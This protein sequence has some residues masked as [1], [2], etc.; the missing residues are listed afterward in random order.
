MMTK[1][2]LRRMAYQA[3]RHPEMALILHDALLETYPRV[4]GDTIERAE[5]LARSWIV[6]RSAG[7]PGVYYVVFF[8]HRLSGKPRP[9]QL[10]DVYSGWSGDRQPDRGPRALARVVRLHMDKVAIAT[11]STSRR[12]PIG[13]DE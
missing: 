1:R 10:F 3:A 5:E 4:Y 12:Y 2:A 11:Y 8:P 9:A 13:G 7:P 6:G